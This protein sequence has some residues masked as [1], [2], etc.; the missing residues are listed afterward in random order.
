MP[1]IDYS[2]LHAPKISS[3]C[4]HS[5]KGSFYLQHTKEISRRYKPYHKYVTVGMKKPIVGANKCSD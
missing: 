1:K 4:G 2:K 3:H 5:K